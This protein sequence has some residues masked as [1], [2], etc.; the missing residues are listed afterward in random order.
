MRADH[1]VEGSD[2]AR[3][4]ALLCRLG[5]TANYA[6]FAQTAYAVSLAA[7]QPERL[8][9][10]TKWLYPDVARHFGT[11]WRC[12]ER[13]IRTVSRMAWQTNRPLLEALAYHPLPGRPAVSVFLA[14][15]TAWLRPGFAGWSGVP[16]RPAASK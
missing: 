14:I 3:V 11:T 12:V 4:R 2:A 7:G 5:V 15:L 6:G 8:L 1:L 10:V 16:G 9:L 13:N